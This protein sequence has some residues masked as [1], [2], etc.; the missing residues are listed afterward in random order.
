MSK[1]LIFIDWDDTLFPTDW[2]QSSNIDLKNPNDVLINMFHDLDILIT[3]MI[4][5]ML[6]L[7]DV[8]IV[9]NGSES[10]INVCISILPNFKQIVDNDAISIT[11][12]RDLFQDEHESKMWKDIAF[13]LFFNEHIS[14]TEGDHHIL[15]FGDSEYE[16]LAVTKLKNYN[17]V[18]NQNRIIKSIKFIKD[19]TLNQLVS[20][21]KTVRMFHEDI[22]NKNEDHIFNLAEFIL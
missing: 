12:A 2:I 19:P 4:I 14:D 8:L 16:H 11:S 22:I 21:L 1:T 10:W 20:Q 13:Q 3:D 6:L 17:P 9:T 7:G 5:S 15:S 18:K